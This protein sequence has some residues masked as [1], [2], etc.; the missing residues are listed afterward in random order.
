MTFRGFSVEEFRGASTGWM[1]YQE[2]RAKAEAELSQMLGIDLEI[3]RKF[4]PPATNSKLTLAYQ[5]IEQDFTGYQSGEL[6]Y[7]G[8][9]FSINDRRSLLSQMFGC[10]YVIS[11]TILIA[12]KAGDNWYLSQGSLDVANKDPAPA[13]QIRRA[14]FNRMKQAGFKLDG[15]IKT[16]AEARQSSPPEPTR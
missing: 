3:F 14:F 4:K 11:P 10:T 8:T 5:F 1:Q 12:C 9:K 13:D 6:L 7:F 2:V 15:A 16:A